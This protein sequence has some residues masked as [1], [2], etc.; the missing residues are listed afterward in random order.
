MTYSFPTGDGITPLHVLT[1]LHRGYGL[2]VAGR[3]RKDRR[4][5]LDWSLVANLAQ[6]VGTVGGLLFVWWQVRQ[7]REVNAYGLSARSCRVHCS[8]PLQP[9]IRRAQPGR[10]SASSFGGGNSQA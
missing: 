10:R 3:A 7:I 8:E 2:G 4:M 9:P 5:S 6:V 1:P